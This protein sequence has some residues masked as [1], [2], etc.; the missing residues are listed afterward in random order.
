MKR[1]G[2]RNVMSNGACCNLHCPN[3]YN[4][5]VRGAVVL[6]SILSCRIHVRGRKDFKG[7]LFLSPLFTQ[8]I[9]EP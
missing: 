2:E 7:H 8:D 5:S 9:S 4:I 1:N 6:Y 3:W